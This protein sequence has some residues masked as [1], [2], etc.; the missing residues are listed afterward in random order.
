MFFFFLNLSTS[1]PLSLSSPTCYCLFSLSLTF[2]FFF[3]PSFYF[4]TWH[5][6]WGVK[7]VVEGGWPLKSVRKSFEKM[8]AIFLSGDT[9]QSLETFLVITTQRG[10][11]AWCFRQPSPLKR[12]HLVVAGDIAKH[13]TMHR[14]PPSALPTKMVQAQISI[15]LRFWETLVPWRWICICE[16]HRG[17]KEWGR[18]CRVLLLSFY[19]QLLAGSL[20]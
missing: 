1:F 14:T 15:V 4:L 17:S 3:F 6:F 11:R 9:W 18:P 10:Q 7:V 12:R 2:F 16:E 8:E 20:I 13:P 5:F 19:P